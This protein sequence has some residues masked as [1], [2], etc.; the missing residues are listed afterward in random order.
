[1]VQGTGQDLRRDSLADG[2]GMGQ[3]IAEVSQCRKTISISAQL[4]T[5]RDSAS[6]A[7]IREL[8]KIL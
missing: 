4:S 2:A 7:V 8:P 3:R 6:S 5:S 1:M